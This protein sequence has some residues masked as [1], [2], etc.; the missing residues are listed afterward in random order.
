MSGPYDPLNGILKSRVLDEPARA[1][2]VREYGSRGEKALSY[3]DKQKVKK[4][5]DFFVVAGTRMEYVVSDDVCT[6]PD[7]AFRQKTC[8]HILAVRIAEITGLYEPVDAW[9]QD[10]GKLSRS[11]W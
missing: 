11:T 8:A 3:I 9:Y 10:T 7:F 2:I 1:G 4:Y 5:L 6:C